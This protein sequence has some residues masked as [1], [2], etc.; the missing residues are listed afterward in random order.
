MW[1][2]VILCIM[3]SLGGYHALSIQ[4]NLALA[5]PARAVGIASDMAT[6]RDAVIAY[7]TANPGHFNVVTLESLRAM[8][9]IPSWSPLSNAANT[10]IWTNYRSSDGTIFIY[11]TSLP[12]ANIV[13]EIAQLSRN[14][15]LA[16]VFRTG[17]TT[18]YS[19]VFGDTGIPL[20]P[21]ADAPIPDG[22]PVWI[23]R[24]N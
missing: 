19:P 7:F 15:I 22:S 5:E 3:V 24:L 16:G 11:A 9:A 4:K 13:F 21:P 18:L 1:Y 6:Y 14:S 17:D 23:A 8:N 12:P 10:S 20:P 2:T